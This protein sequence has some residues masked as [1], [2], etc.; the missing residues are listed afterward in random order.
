[1]FANLEATISQLQLDLVTSLSHSPPDFVYIE[2][3][4][5]RIVSLKKVARMFDDPDV[6]ESNRLHARSAASFS[7]VVTALN[8]LLG[9]RLESHRADLYLR[10]WGAIKDKPSRIVRRHLCLVISNRYP[11]A[12]MRPRPELRLAGS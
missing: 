1:M 7:D 6:I 8:Q 9:E 5:Q 3:L 12:S 2:M 10:A 11:R 4:R